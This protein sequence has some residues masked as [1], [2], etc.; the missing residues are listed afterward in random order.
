VKSV[1][2]KKRDAHSSMA[3]FQLMI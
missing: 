2:K 1:R 3:L